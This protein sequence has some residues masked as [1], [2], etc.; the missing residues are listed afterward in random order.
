MALAS[1]QPIIEMGTRDFYG[2]K[3]RPAREADN[4]AAICD[5]I[6]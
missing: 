4:F 1:T 6:I 3:G 2:D 5:P